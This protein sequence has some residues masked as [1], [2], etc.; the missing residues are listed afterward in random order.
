MKMI[1]DLGIYIKVGT[2]IRNR[3]WLVECPSCLNTFE[4]RAD[5]VKNGNTK[6]CYDCGLLSK[7]KK[8][9]KHSLSNTKLYKRWASMKARC[10]NPNTKGFE[11]WGGRGITVC[12]EW[13][14][15]QTFAIWAYN[16][17]YKENTTNEIHRIDI[18]GNYEPSNCIFVSKDEHRHL[19]RN[20]K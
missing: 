1:Q 14:N 18:E 6:Q 3:Y 20:K 5:Q 13:Q 19:H 10:E 16:N 17:G 8:N 9:I 11:Y 15:V 12:K 7:A 4:T 2:S